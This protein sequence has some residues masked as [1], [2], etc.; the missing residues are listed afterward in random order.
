MRKINYNGKKFKV[1]SNSSGG[2]LE[3]GL[4]FEYWQSGMVLSCTYSGSTILSGHILGK[5]DT[6]N[7]ELHFVYHQI[8]TEE[9][10]SSGKCHSKPEWLPDGRIRLHESWSW[11]S[12]KSGKGKSTLIEI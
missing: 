1:E 9:E 11:I 6:E 7:G 4:V 3:E 2:E 10:L 12:G 5:V 8:N